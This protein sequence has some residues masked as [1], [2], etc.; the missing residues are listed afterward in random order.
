M[1]LATKAGVGRC[2]A[3][4]IP[5]PAAPQ[6]Q[7]QHRAALTVLVASAAGVLL[8][9][10]CPAWAQPDSYSLPNVI[11]VAAATLK[12]SRRVGFLHLLCA[13]TRALPR[14]LGAVG[15]A[16][17]SPCKVRE[18][19]WSCGSSNASQRCSRRDGGALWRPEIALLTRD[20]SRYGGPPE[21]SFKLN[22]RCTRGDDDT[23]RACTSAGSSTRP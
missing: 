16:C 10:V 15:L 11:T 8:R 22:F 1:P 7:R 5:P 19:R 13:A 17:P 3:L 2:R 23:D 20:V 18:R 4:R 21:P 12:A 14:D 6:P 9:V